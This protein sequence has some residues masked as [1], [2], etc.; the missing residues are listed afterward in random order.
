MSILLLLSS[1]TSSYANY[2]DF[3]NPVLFRVCVYVRVV[4]VFYILVDVD[5]SS[6]RNNQQP[7]TKEEEEEDEEDDEYQ[8]ECPVVNK[9]EQG[10]KKQRKYILLINVETPTDE[11]CLRGDETDRKPELCQTN[12][13]VDELTGNAKADVRYLLKTSVV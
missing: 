11:A 13:R 5:E 9:V 3:N 6:Q 1:S 10:V 7:K 12:S 2:D 8:F 4:S